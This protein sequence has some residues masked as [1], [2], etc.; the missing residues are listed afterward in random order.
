MR[1]QKASAWLGALLLGAGLTGGRASETFA[2]EAFERP[3]SP[4]VAL[5]GAARALSSRLP[6][7]TSLETYH[8]FFRELGG[9]CAEVADA[10]RFP[11][12]LLCID[13]HGSVVRAE[14]RPVVR[15]DPVAMTSAEQTLSYGLTGP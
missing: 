14:W 1:V 3:R 10:R 12:T 5:S 7:G 13:G 9:R 11:N 8:A 6:L 2:F 15:F 4:D